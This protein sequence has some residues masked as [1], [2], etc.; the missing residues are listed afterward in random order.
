MR[1]I[2]LEHYICRDCGAEK[3]ICHTAQ[4]QQLSDIE[5]GIIR[6]NGCGTEYSVVKGIPRFVPV[7]NYASSFGYQWNIHRR[8]QLDS[9]TG[10]PISKNRVFA[11]TG[12]S[13]CLAGQTILEAGSGAGRFTE[14]LLG[15]GADV[16]SFDFSNAVEANWVNNGNNPQMH[17]FQGDIF[18]VPLRKSS[19]DKV[20]CLGVLQHTPDPDRAFKS[21]AEFVRP[22]GELVIDVYTKS[23]LHLCQWKYFLRP[24][25]KRMNK[26]LLYKIISAIV[27][28]LIPMAKLFRK[29]G[30]KYGSRLLPIVEYSYLGISEHLNDQ[31][32]ILDTFDMF[33]PMYDHPQT[34]ASVNNWFKD[35][36]FEDVKVGYGPNGVIGKGKKPL[37]NSN[38]SG[39]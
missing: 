1:L 31:W 3:L 10:L 19:F 2:D 34:L 12:W 25:T 13:E 32:A 15:T 27:P 38:G 28:K 18:H 24:L 20:F 36:G 11:V 33:S 4:G 37:K 39:R 16:F 35:A 9:N 8:T 30:G 23:F 17:L 7:E 26:E 21:L 29:L 6:C 14:I 5:E 22:G